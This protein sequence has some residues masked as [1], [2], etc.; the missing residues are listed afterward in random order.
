MWSFMFSLK[1]QFKWVKEHLGKY[2]LDRLILTFDK[3]LIKGNILIDDQHQIRGSTSYDIMLL[4]FKI[5][6]AD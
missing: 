5:K 1:F 6:A 4:N 2:W 3:T